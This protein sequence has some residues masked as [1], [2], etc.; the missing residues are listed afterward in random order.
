M[1]CPYL[2]ENGIVGKMPQLKKILPAASLLAVVALAGVIGAYRVNTVDTPWHLRTGAWIVEHHAVPTVDFFSFTRAGLVWIDAQWLFQVTAWAWQAAL[3][4]AGLTLMVMALAIGLTLAV[5]LAPG[6]PPLPVR[7][8]AGLVF[9]LAAN[10]RLLCRPELL[11]CLLLALLLFALERAVAGRPRW[12][13]AAGLCQLLLVNA[14]GLWPLGLAVAGAVMFDRPAL[15]PGRLPGQRL[16]GRALR[17]WLVFAG[18]VMVSG[19]LQ[20]YGRRGFLFPLTLLYEIA[21]PAAAHKRI[22]A[23]FQPLL[24]YPWI[25]RTAVPFLV[26]AAL[27]VAATAAA[28]RERRWGLAALAAGFIG[29]ALLAR[30]NVGVAAVVNGHGLIVHLGALWRRRPLP[31]VGVA[32]GAVAAL[33]AVALIPFMLQ[34]PRV[35]DDT[36]REPGFGFSEKYLP[37]RAAEFLAGIGYRGRIVNTEGT[38]GW[39]IY[40]G[41]PGW[42]V[43]ADSRFEVGGEA[44]LELYRQ[45]F[46]RPEDLTA[47]ADRWGVA[48]LFVN[49]RSEEMRRFLPAVMAEGAFIPVYQDERVMVLL[50]DGPRW[51]AV[52]AARGL[53]GP[54]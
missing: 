19:F 28:G 12:L 48:A 38:G 53:P 17:P 47:T 24:A 25:A 31:R 40:K 37:V 20:P 49:F 52:I 33:A 9:L 21:S 11:S 44:A 14:E 46:G 43:F 54:R 32:A 13:W 30:R 26:L 3:G 16:G 29:L 23:E 41:W 27:N 8:V 2:V 18:F 51:R 36:L 6:G 1:L 42:S 15:S 35:I 45:V 4:D 39:L 22:I 34:N 5:T 10:P 50:R 7:A